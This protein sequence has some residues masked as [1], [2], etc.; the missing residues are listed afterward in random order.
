MNMN[1]VLKAR[2]EHEV[3]YQDLYE[4]VRKHADKLSAIELLAVAANMLG[5]LVAMQDQCIISPQ[6][7]MEVVVRNLESG[8]QQ[9]IAQLLQS[10][11]AD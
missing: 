8:N 3:A 2:P 7:A 5:K 4:L 11:G 6:E 9:A 10:N 1:N